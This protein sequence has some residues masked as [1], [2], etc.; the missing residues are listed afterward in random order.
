M[1]H[2][3]PRLIADIGGTNA[4]F[5]LEIAPYEL[6]AIQV[7]ACADY[8]SLTD[9]LR[10][11]VE[12]QQIELPQ[13]IGIAIANPIDGD[14]ITMT[15][16]HWSFSISEMKAELGVAEL[17]FVNDFTAQSLAITQMNADNVTLLSGTADTQLL[18]TDKVSTV[19]GAG[20]G[21]GTSGLVPKGDGT[22]IAL[23]SEG[24][25]TT[26][27]PTSELQQELQ[28]FVAQS[29]YD[30][31]A[32]KTQN[33]AS[34]DDTHVSAERLLQGAGIVLNYQFLAHKLQQPL[35]HTTPAEVTTAALQ[36][37]ELCKKALHLYCDI[38]GSFCGNVVLTLGGTGGLYLTGGIVPRFVDF[39]Q[40]SNFRNAFESKGRL[41]R[42]L[43]PV[44]V[45]VVKHSQPGLL[46]AAVALNNYML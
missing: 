31:N 26:F 3:Y 36:D 39:L 6:T 24:G 27:S 12:Q 25:H 20:T 43:R 34:L 18:P 42:L 8:A 11:Y 16:H 17:I 30:G 7:L 29:L 41:S 40:Q 5:S 44:P 22:M 28:R 19:V 35:H 23:A 1:Q 37:D 2:T 38:L 45:Y 15:N 46:G 14:T 32:D 9:A 4:R 21:L 33:N 13:Y 10:T